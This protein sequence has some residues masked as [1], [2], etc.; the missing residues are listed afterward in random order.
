MQVSFLKQCFLGF[1]WYN[2]SIVEESK[3]DE[4]IRY[5]NLSELSQYIFSITK[6]IEDLSNKPIQMKKEFDS[7]C[8]QETKNFNRLLNYFN[9]IENS[10]FP[11]NFWNSNKSNPKITNKGSLKDIIEKIKK[12]NTALKNISDTS[13]VVNTPN[14]ESLVLS[15]LGNIVKNKEIERLK[16]SENDRKV[17]IEKSEKEHR[18]SLYFPEKERIVTDS[19]K[20]EILKNVKEKSGIGKELDYEILENKIIPTEQSVKEFFEYRKTGVHNG[21]GGSNSKGGYSMEMI[22][23]QKESNDLAFEKM[24]LNFKYL[25]G[26]EI[27]TKTKQERLSWI[28]SVIVNT[29]KK[30]KL[31]SNDPV[32]VEFS[33]IIVQPYFFLF[34]FEEDFIELLSDIKKDKDFFRKHNMT[35]YNLEFEIDPLHKEDGIIKFSDFTDDFIKEYTED[36][37]NIKN[38]ASS[39]FYLN[40]EKE[41]IKTK[42]NGKYSEAGEDI[43][44]KLLGIKIKDNLIIRGKNEIKIN[45][46]EK[47]LIYY[48]FY[49]STTNEEECFSLK[50]LSEAKEI[51]TE[52]EG[53]I[54]NCIININKLIKKIISRTVNVSIPKFIIKEKNKRGYHLNPK[55]IHIKRKKEKI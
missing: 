4:Y 8:K 55:I 51:K 5:Q 48:L 38:S 13:N 50:D 10:P 16:N 21:W 12:E 20:M 24:I 17:R 26:M 47:A 33:E 49:K 14:T 9:S 1:S 34:T 6:I 37:L 27:K 53:Y 46:T 18:M 31:A 2:A 23:P 30:N 36:R 44:L 45:S 19:E 54:E 29:K 22:N 40:G 41:E 39:L 25:H 32:Y 28:F 42:D 52:S 11:S 43:L 3:E 7:F 15:A 35:S